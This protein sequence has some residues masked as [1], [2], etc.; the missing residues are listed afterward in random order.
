MHR[1]GGEMEGGGGALSSLFHSIRC[2]VAMVIHVSAIF[3][4]AVL[5]V[6]DVN[7]L[8]VLKTRWGYDV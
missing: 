1:G 2:D 7:A 8:S 5:R 6:N 3:D 4:M